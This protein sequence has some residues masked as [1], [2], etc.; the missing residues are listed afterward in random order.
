MWI[1]G[2]LLSFGIFDATLI[3]AF[4]LRFAVNLYFELKLN[5]FFIFNMTVLYVYQKIVIFNMTVSI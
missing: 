5:K 2:Y 1:Y 4:K 3:S